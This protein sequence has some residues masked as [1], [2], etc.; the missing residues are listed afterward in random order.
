[1]N[2]QL[3]EWLK[4]VQKIGESLRLMELAEYGA[5]MYW[6]PWDRFVALAFYRHRC[7][8][9]YDEQDTRAICDRYKWLCENIGPTHRGWRSR[10]FTNFQHD[11]KFEVDT[12]EIEYYFRTKKDLLV[13]LLRWA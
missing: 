8:L 5:D 10:I 12:S 13:F 2:E 7:L 4:I 11:R 1:M 3:E 9:P 6:S